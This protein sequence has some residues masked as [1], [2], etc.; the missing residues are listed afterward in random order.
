MCVE[1]MLF[2][3]IIIGCWGGVCFEDIFWFEFVVKYVVDFYYG[4]VVVVLDGKY[5]FVCCFD[6]FSFG[7]VEKML[8]GVFYIVVMV[9]LIEF[10]LICVMLVF[11]SI[12]EG[13][14]VFLL[15]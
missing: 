5:G 8:Y 9:G 12:V 11:I 3:F 10:E 14:F 13:N 2:G 15:L 4:N 7:D 6:V 1:L